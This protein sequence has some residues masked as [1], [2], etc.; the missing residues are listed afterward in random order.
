MRIAFLPSS[1]LPTSVGGTELYV[2]NLAAA[3]TGAGHQA[4]IVHHAE[5][6]GDAVVN[7][8]QVFRLPPHLPT[9]RSDL[10]RYSTGQDPAGFEAFL[11]HWRPDA[12][13]F[14]AL[15]L[16]AGLDH[17]RVIR[18]LGIP[19]FITYHTPSFSCQ[20]G[21]LMRWGK[22]RCDGIVRPYTCAACSFEGLGYSR[23][24]SRLL[25]AS[26]LPYG[27]LPE[28]PWVT[29]L[30]AQSLLA[31]RL[32][33]WL[34]FLRGACRIIA[35]AEWCRDVLV[36][37]GVDRA[38]ICVHRQAL[39]GPDRT[40]VLRSP[41]G[42]KRPARLGFFGRFTWVKG[43]DLLLE[44]AR[45]LNSLGH[46]TQVDLVGPIEQ[47]ERSWADKLLTS[48]KAYASYLGVKRDA[49]LTEWLDN[50]DLVAIPSRCLETG[51]LTLLEAWDRGVPVVGS[52]LGGLKEFMAAANL[53]SLLFEP[54]NPD[55][56]ATA[57]L[58]C[59]SRRSDEPPVVRIDGMES[60]AR[61]HVEIYGS[62]L[63]DQEPRHPVP[64]HA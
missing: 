33:G 39:P 8:N 6:P 48:H 34:D 14:H 28:G 17:C 12:V 23:L 18:R 27:L 19:Y 2:H 13:H 32:P 42:V 58:A 25:A 45:R 63:S 36:A 57:I 53:Q 5:N 54:E 15:T 3:L 21:S 62:A 41:V 59:L 43:P 50:L 26:P 38:A 64:A 9:K 37:N 29:G 1:Y 30:A 4:A 24:T 60:L 7:G 16:G 52:N 55:A 49:A 35:C 11:A 51:P 10:Y 56:L 31:S 47:S 20:R 22:S 44:A 40:R 61:K 46:S